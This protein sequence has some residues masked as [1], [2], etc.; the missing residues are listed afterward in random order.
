M[1]YWM[2]RNLEPLV[3]S[4]LIRDEMKL[5]T[6]HRHLRNDNTVFWCTTV[7]L[8][9]GKHSS[10][11]RFISFQSISKQLAAVCTHATPIWSWQ[12]FLCVYF[13][14]SSFNVW[15]KEIKLMGQTELFFGLLDPELPFFCYFKQSSDSGSSRKLR[16][17]AHPVKG[18]FGE[19]NWEGLFA[20]TFWL[21]RVTV[22]ESKNFIWNERN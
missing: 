22:N 6:R 14:L 20:R 15:W 4:R 8:P 10:V 11:N 21:F 12:A 9:N 19:T 1:F 17:G 7:R 3:L 16:A 5:S 2:K 18:Y 13:Q